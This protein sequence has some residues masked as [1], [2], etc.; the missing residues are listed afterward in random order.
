MRKRLS[1]RCF[2]APMFALRVNIGALD[3]FCAPL[4]ARSANQHEDDMGALGAARRR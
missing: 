3:W 2:G 1:A 4:S